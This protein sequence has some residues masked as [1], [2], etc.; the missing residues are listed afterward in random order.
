MKSRAPTHLVLLPYPSLILKRNAFT[1]GLI[2]RVLQS[3]DDGVYSHDLPAKFYTI[4]ESPTRLRRLSSG[5]LTMCDP[6]KCSSFRLYV[7]FFS[8]PLVFLFFFSFYFFL[9][10]FWIYKIES[11]FH[12]IVSYDMHDNQT[13]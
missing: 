7:S 12:C 6:R 10:F 9:F 2:A 4:T 1:A 5:L 3:S 8:L 11:V 13:I